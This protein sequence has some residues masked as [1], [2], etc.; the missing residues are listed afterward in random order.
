LV[1]NIPEF[2]DEFDQNKSIIKRNIKIAKSFSTFV[3]EKRTNLAEKS[4]E[5]SKLV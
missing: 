5:R 3:E 2:S 1:I 4:M